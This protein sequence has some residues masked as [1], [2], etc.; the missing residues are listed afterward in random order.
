MAGRRGRPCG[1]CAPA[2]AWRPTR[3]STTSSRARSPGCAAAGSTIGPVT[4]GSR[5][6]PDGEKVEWWTATV[7]ELGPDR[8]PFL[9]QH[10][11]IGAEW[12]DEARERRRTFVHPVGTP[13]ALTGLDLATADPASLA[14]AYA[15]E[16]GMHFDQGADVASLRVGPHEVRLLPQEMVPV[17]HLVGGAAAV[18]AELIGVRFEITPQPGS[19]PTS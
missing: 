4:P 11:Y 18:S 19:A 16:L 10:A 9:I 12:G 14:Q 7:D 1:R 17:V 6:R 8:P 15:R 5:T 13:V 3:C 2:A